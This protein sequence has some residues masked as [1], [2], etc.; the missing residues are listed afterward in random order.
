VLV[1]GQPTI[2]DI[3]GTEQAALSE[4]GI[5]FMPEDG[6]R[7]HIDA[8]Q[9]VRVLADWTPPFPVYHLYDPSRRQQSLAFSAQID[10][11]RHCG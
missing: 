4:V 6:A 1:E 7:P 9:L 10:A 11:L 5:A 8:G 3:G 2:N